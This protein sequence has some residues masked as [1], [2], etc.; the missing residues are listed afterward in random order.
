MDKGFSA[1]AFDVFLFVSE[2]STADNSITDVHMR[3]SDVSFLL[4]KRSFSR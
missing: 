3:S 2:E 1:A 4:E